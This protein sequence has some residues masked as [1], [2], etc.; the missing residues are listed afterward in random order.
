MLGKVKEGLRKAGDKLLDL[1]AA[2]A[3]KVDAL[4]GNPVKREGQMTSG[5]PIREFFKEQANVQADT[6]QSG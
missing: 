5:M 4:H 6:R 3:G 2:Y 1:D